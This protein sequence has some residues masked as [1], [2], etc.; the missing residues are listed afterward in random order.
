M[1]LVIGTQPAVIR[2]SFVDARLKLEWD[3]ARLEILTAQLPVR[4]IAR[5]ERALQAVLGTAFPIE[6]LVAFLNDL[7]RDQRQ[8]GFAERGGLPEK[9]I[10]A[11]V[12][13][14][15]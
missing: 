3:V 2:A 15:R 12:T 8:A 9:D 14:R 7:R 1:L 4:G 10:G 13:H 11:R 6:D 5:D